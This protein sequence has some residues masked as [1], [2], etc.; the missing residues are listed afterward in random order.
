MKVVWRTPASLDLISLAENHAAYGARFANNIL[1]RIEA[2]VALLEQFP[3]AGRPG[4]ISGTKE[5]P[6]PGTPYVIHYQ[7]EAEEI[8]ILNILHGAR[9]FPPEP[10]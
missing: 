2:Q 6:V 10:E 4:Q 8:S 7:I 5:R 9:K 3:F 1:D